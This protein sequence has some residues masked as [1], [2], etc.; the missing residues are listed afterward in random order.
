MVGYSQAFTS[1]AETS[2][3]AGRLLIVAKADRAHLLATRH[4][5][6]HFAGTPRL[7]AGQR[8]GAPGLP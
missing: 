4:R 8:P 2:L 6:A 3:G 7:S 1:G 5:L